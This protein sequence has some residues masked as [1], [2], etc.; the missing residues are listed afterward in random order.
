MC[1]LFTTVQSLSRILLLSVI[2]CEQSMKFGIFWINEFIFWI[3]WNLRPI[4]LQKSEICPY[5][6]SNYQLCISYFIQLLLYYPLV[7]SPLKNNPNKNC[8]VSLSKLYYFSLC[9]EI[10]CICLKISLKDWLKKGWMRNR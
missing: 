3:K 5:I 6:S 9:N 1:V 7:F 4:L 2:L 8:L 10:P